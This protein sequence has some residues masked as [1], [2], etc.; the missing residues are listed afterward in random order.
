MLLGK[1]DDAK[2]VQLASYM[3]KLRVLAAPV[4][5][6]VHET[7]I[8]TFDTNTALETAG[9]LEPDMRPLTA[10]AAFMAESK[11]SHAFMEEKFRPEKLAEATD[12]MDSEGNVVLIFGECKGAIGEVAG[13]LERAQR[14]MAKLW[15]ASALILNETF[16]QITPDWKTAIGDEKTDKEV[17]KAQVKEVVIDNPHRQTLNTL[18]SKG[19]KAIKEFK[20]F[21]K[22][23][24]G[25]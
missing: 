2:A 18:H 13:F 6:S 19:A 5:I 15:H 20:E 3:D 12:V 24:L 22:L 25:T 17:I 10:L 1:N 4:L 7:A 23:D 16:R 11:K 8:P 21:E 9:S 14:Y